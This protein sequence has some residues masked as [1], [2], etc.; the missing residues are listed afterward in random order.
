MSRSNVRGLVAFSVGIPIWPSHKPDTRLRYTRLP[1]LHPLPDPQMFPFSRLSARFSPFFF[2]TPPLP[3]LS[4]FARAFAHETGEF[5]ARKTE[6]GKQGKGWRVGRGKQGILSCLPPPPRCSTLWRG[7]GMGIWRMERGKGGR[8]C[9]NSLR[10]I[11]D[12]RVDFWFWRVQAFKDNDLIFGICRCWVKLINGKVDW[13]FFKRVVV[14]E[15]LP[16]FMR[17]F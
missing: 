2:P 9:V 16:F 7:R 11:I 4:F 15:F 6:V 3:P 12:R 5:Q 1:T 14:Y 17:G 10:C 13:F 8:R